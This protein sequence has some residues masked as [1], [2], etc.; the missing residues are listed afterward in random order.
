MSACA[1]QSLRPHS[2]TGDQPAQAPAVP[3]LREGLNALP[4]TK[5]RGGA[6]ALGRSELSRLRQSANHRPLTF[7]AER[8][9]RELTD[10]DI[11]RIADTNDAWRGEQGAG[12]YA[13]VPG[14]CKSATLEEIRKHGHVLTPCRSV[15]AEAQEGNG[16]PFDEKTKRLVAAL[17]EQQA[18]AAK[19]NAAMA[20]NLKG[21]RYG[22]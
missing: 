5:G 1:E 2:G 9:H 14:F 11:A 15:G 18:E 6:P 12:T 7:S 20:A 3:G 21:L 16:E 19:L 13:D 22:G 10:E 8:S 17:R 4:P